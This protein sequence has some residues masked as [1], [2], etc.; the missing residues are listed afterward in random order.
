[1]KH[2]ILNDSFLLDILELPA[3]EPKSAGG[4]GTF[5]SISIGGLG[6][7]QLKAIRFDTYVPMPVDGQ[8]WLRPVFTPAIWERSDHDAGFSGVELLVSLAE[9]YDAVN[10]P[11]RSEKAPSD[12]VTEWCTGHIHPYNQQA[13]LD[14]LELERILAKPEYNAVNVPDDDPMKQLLPAVIPVGE[15]GNPYWKPG[16]RIEDCAAFPLNGFLADLHR[17]I[18][19]FYTYIAISDLK[20]DDP[21]A[22]KGLYYIGKHYDGPALFEH[23]KATCR[24]P[25]ADDA[26]MYGFADMFPPLRMEMVYDYDGDC[27]KL[28]PVVRSV[29]DVCWYTL[30]C[31]TGLADQVDPGN[32]RYRFVRC[33]ACGKLITAY[34][35]QRYCRDPECQKKR[36][37]EKSRASHARR[38]KDVLPNVLPNGK[39]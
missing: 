22:A 14:E 13:V 30:S 36:N 11:G 18:S 24:S 25:W 31:V 3:K 34:G 6:D 21:E 23:F 9:L 5:Q 2:N 8:F 16:I 37:R 15:S 29:F 7:I 4:L 17:L 1:M 35:Q 39:H 32:R 26:V 10:R 27:M 19:A 20:N 38:S 28:V 12:L 33:E